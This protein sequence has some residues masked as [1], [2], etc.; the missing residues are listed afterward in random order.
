VAFYSAVLGPVAFLILINIVVFVFV[1]RSIIAAGRGLRT[2]QS[3]SKQIKEKLLASFLNFVLLGL[4]WIFG[5][6]SIGATNAVVFS[7]LFCVTSSLQGFIIF[8][9]YVGRDPSARKQWILC[10]RVIAFRSRNWFNKLQAK[11][12]YTKYGNSSFYYDVTS[13][14]CL[15]TSTTGNDGSTSPIRAS[16]SEVV[17]T[18]WKVDVRVATRE[19]TRNTN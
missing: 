10:I 16:I 5:F 6:F 8:V 12:P 9:L 13:E 1:V 17:A 3:E 19:P 7:Y 2:N 14:S 18:P 15:T 4:T 11:S